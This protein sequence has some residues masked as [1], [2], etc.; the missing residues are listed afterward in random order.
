MPI[1]LLGA[2]ML[3]P[4]PVVPECHLSCLYSSPRGRI[5]DTNKV[6]AAIVFHLI[7][8]FIS[9]N[10]SH[11]KSGPNGIT[12]AIMRQEPVGKLCH[13]DNPGRSEPSQD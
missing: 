10:L 4:F 1:M 7:P 11:K 6:S 2:P 13:R 5:Y 12:G 8:L 9:H 3:C